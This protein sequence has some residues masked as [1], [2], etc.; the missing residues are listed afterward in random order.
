MRIV[1]VQRSTDAHEVLRAPGGA[2]SLPWSSVVQTL[3]RHDIPD[4]LPF[5]VDDDGSLTSCDRLNTYLLTAWRQRAYDLDSLRTFHAYHLARLLRF[6]R[7]R[8]GGELVDLTA[9]TTEDLT[10]YR[11]ARQQEVQDT[12]LATE[13]GCFSSFFYFSTQVG[14]MEKDP[15]P[16]WG[17][18]NRNTLISRTRRERQARFLKA[19]QTKHFLEVGLRGDGYD[20]EGAPGYPERDY[21]YGLL[22]ATTGLRREECAFLLDTEVPVPNTMGSESVHIFDR[23]GKKQVVRSIY[24]TAHV[25]H[26]ADLY[27]QTERHRIA[28]AA[29]RSLRAKVREGSLLVIDALIERRGKLYVAKGSQRIPLV[30]FTNQNRGQAVRVLDDGTID[31]LALFVSRTG[32]PP[33]LE[34]WNQLFADA[35]ERVR[36]SDHRDQPPRHVHVT[37]HTMRHSY[38]VRMLAALMKEGRQRAGDPYLLLANPVLTV[39]ELLGHASVQTTMHYLHAAETWTENVPA[40]LAATAADLVGHTESDPGPDAETIDD[41]WEPDASP[42]TG[43]VQ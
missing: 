5:I 23:L 39:K 35:R 37:P 32:L 4:G 33:G 40:A 14:W 11:D 30:R 1:A 15:I 13:F 34:R 3:D 12:T 16:R 28:Q 36:H 26:A 10:A 9:T 43:A 2:A 25:A 31:P 38:A 19:A 24:I 6:V 22:L 29:Q 18:N 27:R 21:V 8:R 7:A 17:R 42:A 41:D 20:L